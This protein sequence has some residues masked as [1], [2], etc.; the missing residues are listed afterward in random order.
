[1]FKAKS[2]SVAVEIDRLRIMN[3]SLRVSAFSAKI[4]NLNEFYQHVTN[5]QQLPSGLDIVN[6]LR[7]F[8]QTLLGILRDVQGTSTETFLSIKSDVSRATLFPNLNYNGL[9]NALNN[10]ID[11]YPL[12][13]T[14]Q[15]ALGNAILNTIHCVYLFLDREHAEQLPYNVASLLSIYPS[16]LYPDVL[17]LLCNVLLPF[18]L[19]NESG[20]SY[21]T[22]SVSS[23]ILLVFQYC[24][25]PRHHTWLIETLMSLRCDVYKDI[26]S[27]IAYGTTESRIPAVNLLFHYWPLS[28]ADFIDRKTA[29]YKIHAW[30]PTRCQQRNCNSGDENL[31]TKKCYD[32]SYC[33]EYGDIA[34]PLFLCSQCAQE[35]PDALRSSL[36]PYF[37]PLSTLANICQ[38]KECTSSNRLAVS[39][40]FSDEC[41]RLNN[42][43]PSRLCEQCHRQRHQNVNHT[44]LEAIPSA[45]NCEPKFFADMITAIV[46]LLKETSVLI[47][48]VHA[49][50]LPKWL[51]QLEGSDQSKKTLT[52]E[53]R[54]LS[55]YG[56]KMLISFCPPIE[57][58]SQ[59]AIG[60]LLAALFQWFATT[61][62]LPSDCIGTSI[63]QLKSEFVCNWLRRIIES[64]YGMF[65]QCLLPKPPSFA[66]VGGAWDKLSKRSDQLKDGL[67]KI[68]A[69]I[70]YDLIS[71]DVIFLSD[72]VIDEITWERI[73]P[74]WFDVMSNE[75]PESDLPELKVLL[76]KIF[77]VDLC[78]LSFPSNQ[79]YHFIQVRL[80]GDSFKEQESALCWLQLLTDIDIVIPMDTLL[81]LLKLGAKS[82]FS[83]QPVTTEGLS[84]KEHMND[85]ESSLFAEED[86]MHFS[87]DMHHSHRQS[88][89]STNDSTS[90]VLFIVILDILMRQMELGGFNKNQATSSIMEQNIMC[91]IID[92]IKLPWLGMH[93]CSNVE[94]DQFA[95]CVYC[96]DSTIFF[97]LAMET[98]ATLCPS[99][100][101]AVFESSD[102]MHGKQSTA[103]RTFG[104]SAVR[105][106]AKLENCFS[107]D[108]KD[109]KEVESFV[110]SEGVHNLKRRSAIVGDNVNTSGA[111]SAV[112]QEEYPEE[113]VG[114]LPVEEPEVATVEA[115]T[116]TDSELEQANCK[117]VTTTTMMDVCDSPTEI[118]K[119]TE[120]AVDDSFWYTSLGKFRFRIEDLPAE[121]RL[122]HAYMTTVEDHPNP[123]VRYF[124][125][126]TIKC[127]C[128]NLN[129][130][131]NAQFERRGFLIWAQ[132]NILIPKFWKLLRSQYSQ[133]SE[134]CACLIFHCLSLPCGA[135]VFWSTVSRDFVNSDFRTRLEAVEKVTVLSWFI[136]APS[137]KN[138]VN[139]EGALAIAFVFLISATN[140][141][142]STVA[143][144]ALISVQ[145]I[146]ESSL[147]C[148]CKSLES[149]F[150][151][152]IEDR[153]LM[154]HQFLV[155]SSVLQN[156]PVLNWEFFQNRFEALSKEAQMQLQTTGKITFPG[157]YYLHD[158][159]VEIYR[160]KSSLARHLA[161][162]GETLRSIQRYLINCLT[163]L[164]KNMDDSL[165]IT[166]AYFLKGESSSQ[167]VESNNQTNNIEVNLFDLPSTI[168][169][170]Q[171]QSSFGCKSNAVNEDS[172]DGTSTTPMDN[173]LRESVRL[174]I[175]LFMKFLSNSRTACVNADEKASAKR[176][177][178]VLRHLN[179]LLG[180]NVQ[181][182]TF[183]VPA[184]RLRQ[185]L[186]IYIRLCIF[187]IFLLFN[188]R[189]SAICNS[190]LSNLP[191][192]LD[193]NVFFVRQI[194]PLAS[195]L[196]V[197]LPSPPKMFAPNSSVSIT[198]DCTLWCLEP[199]MRQ[200]WMWSLLLILYKYQFD[201]PPI[202][203][204][205]LNMIRIVI[206]TLNSQVHSCVRL[207]MSMHSPSFRSTM[208]PY[209]KGVRS[210]PEESRRTRLQTSINNVRILVRT[211]RYWPISS[212]SSN[213]SL[214]QSKSTDSSSIAGSCESVSTEQDETS[215]ITANISASATS[216]SAM[217]ASVSSTV[218]RK[219]RALPQRQLTFDE[220]EEHHL[221]D[222]EY[223]ES[224]KIDAKLTATTSKDSLN[225]V[226][227]SDRLHL[228][229]SSKHKPTAVDGRISSL[230]S[231]GDDTVSVETF[232]PEEQFA[233][234]V[235]EPSP[236][237][238][239]AVH[240]DFEIA[241][242]VQRVQNE[243]LASAYLVQPPAVVVLP[244]LTENGTS[245]NVEIVAKP[246]EATVITEKVEPAFCCATANRVDDDIGNAKT[247]PVHK[248]HSD[249][250]SV[251]VQAKS[252]S[253]ILQQHQVAKPV[254]LGQMRLSD[255]V[256]QARC[257]HCNAILEICDE[258][259]ISL[260]IVC[261]STFVH[262]D[263]SMAA[264]QLLSMLT[265]VS[266]IAA[267]TFHPWQ[268]RTNIF[269][270]S[271][272]RSV[273]R[274]F[275]RIVLHQLAPNRLFLSLFESE[276]EDE[277]FFKTVALCLADF[278][279][280]NPVSVIQHLMEDLH[281]STPDNVALVLSNL[282][283][284]MRHISYDTHLPTWTTV[285]GLFDNFFRHILT[286]NAD[287][288]LCVGHLF[289]ILNRLFKISNFGTI[290]PSLTLL[291]TCCKFITRLLLDYPLNLVDVIALCSS[292][293]RAFVKERDK[294][295]LTRCCLNEFCQ[296]LKFKHTL[297]DVNYMMVIKLI[298]YDFGE[299][300]DCSLDRMMFATSAADCAR[301]FLPDFIE[302]LQDYHVLNRMKALCIGFNL[303]IEINLKNSFQMVARENGGLCEDTLGGELK[304]GLAKYVAHEIYRSVSR[305]SRSIYRFLPWLSSPPTVT[306]LGANEF[307]DC[308]GRVRLLSWVL[309]GSLSSCSS[310]FNMPLPIECS[311]RI[312]DY[313]QFVLA[314]FAELSN[315]SV[316][317]M[318]ALF[319]AFHL[320]QL[321]TV[322]CEEAV[323]H[324][325]DDSVKEDA[326]ASVMDFW[327]RIT[328]AI[329]QLLSH[330]KVLA[331]MVNLHF[332]N[333]V[334]GLLEADSVVL[335][336][337]YPMWYPILSAYHTNI[338]SHL[339]V[340]L[341]FFENSIHSSSER[342]LK[343]WLK[344]ISFKIGQVE[345]QSSAATQFYSV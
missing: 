59:D 250:G 109:G 237:P 15:I 81:N 63:E 151:L 29:E 275:I 294:H 38:N 70:P 25:D 307:V 298:L 229:A 49:E 186:Y 133:V 257:F 78:S 111:F 344:K 271:N 325:L 121:L 152:V 93:T 313:I 270:P 191:K 291:D 180:F 199:H 278:Q 142:N 302:F 222:M 262:R 140:D 155:L 279:E 60:H 23:I 90:V 96:R 337:L 88:V 233:I 263:P 184:H 171:K 114:I 193:N 230:D 163:E 247:V 341:D 72:F 40:C 69:L 185:C 106:E 181:E 295:T 345:L 83:F 147:K 56:I 255:S 115:V 144:R 128:L 10:I 5:S 232:K 122:I 158:N 55:A 174:I 178:S 22:A 145:T 100:G 162:K 206:C 154:M 33:A 46:S 120:S 47:E 200:H 85:P 312:S 75:I 45:W 67:S 99:L 65:V 107:V 177:S 214:I 314:G 228:L 248:V 169:Q 51:Q 265:A 254:F 188:F 17:R 192:V 164:Q 330:S 342:D 320:C 216:K 35:V 146:K 37:Q 303:K 9:Y 251:V 268:A 14:G 74:D 218:A 328:P 108:R 101:R 189:S 333:T 34:P 308:V 124:M 327:S 336:K 195:S 136:D 219:R 277:L 284:Y 166:Y 334:E 16:E 86:M 31:S 20:N 19:Y 261:L 7:Y 309:L 105:E 319:H 26:M 259:T 280:L 203:E 305:D 316:L 4:R 207:Q 267:H 236:Q 165:R 276:I 258:D 156:V 148:L 73:M 141:H 253:P 119:K 285:V 220:R 112:V 293:N 231:T 43:I 24:K 274:Q 28:K 318:S 57:N 246:M 104:E 198:S 331:D 242:P 143:Q 332:L 187:T 125:L 41:V 44:Y 123:D 238:F 223:G 117:V 282:A 130:L 8:Q 137:V 21:A 139:I 172:S 71:F 91:V 287:L 82:V 153:A 221:E 58:A 290:R 48:E 243:Q 190:F 202:N 27:V 116:V 306:Q 98:V 296:A 310:S 102:K 12:V 208:F 3:M 249:P 212:R 160:H 170:L 127:L 297:H 196:L 113:F 159:M 138:N 36:F 301:P 317:N 161:D 183:T 211:L 94:C 204:A 32:S 227:K 289:Q 217:T 18:T 283:E 131:K 92:I 286:N 175:T 300:D 194:L 241:A 87:S 326:M 79:I 6:T 182:R 281:K 80:Q 53:R 66:K 168:K 339:M 30:A 150:D 110:D 149:Q 343:P 13:T 97:Q 68:L 197:Y 266:K 338:P 62:L 42:F 54:T 39:T 252:V 235:L 335:T 340:R 304:I 84:F 256:I 77:E 179:M 329:L 260:G 134:V 215:E 205:V 240:P 234:A 64:H 269:V 225:V 288:S 126:T 315:Q 244:S 201:Q 61:A 76:C 226:H 292:C 89:F 272:C 95:D 176:Q 167:K 118:A 157:D 323:L 245:D 50:K 264:P 173:T 209:L 132:E 239:Q 322:Y 1:M 311:H 210:T 103:S 324:A 135:D 52:D 11:I 224:G 299:T 273:A 213:E 321:W 2:V 129:A